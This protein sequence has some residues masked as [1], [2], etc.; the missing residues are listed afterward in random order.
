MRGKEVAF[1]AIENDLD[2]VLETIEKEFD[3]KYVKSGSFEKREATIYS[4]FAEIP[5]LGFTE[6]GDWVGSDHRFLVMP[7]NASVTLEAVSQESG[8]V[9]FFVD[10]EGN[11]DSIE[12]TVNGIYTRKEG[13]IVAGRIATVSVSAFASSLY[14]S[15]SL[16]IK[17]RFERIGGYY[18]GQNA[19]ERLKA[20][21]RLVQIEKSPREYDLVY[22]DR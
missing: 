10:P 12:L 15:L 11:P 4:S 1:F 13:V 17:K 19:V 2:S 16:K 21:W 3:L 7:K 22:T 14:K 9:L 8:G 20:G 5:N 6:A 18:V